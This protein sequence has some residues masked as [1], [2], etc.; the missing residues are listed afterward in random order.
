[1]KNT[2]HIYL[3]MSALASLLVVGCAGTTASEQPAHQPP[4]SETAA[5]QSQPAPELTKAAARSAQN[6]TPRADRPVA[7]APADLSQSKPAAAKKF[8]HIELARQ[9]RPEPRIVHF[10]FDKTAIEARDRE[11]LKQH[12]TYL[13]NHPEAIL[14]IQGHTDHHGPKA[15]N[16]YLSKQRAEAVARTLIEYGAPESQLVIDAMGDSQPLP[17]PHTTA[18]NRRVELNYQIL[19]MVHSH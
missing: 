16:E 5:R 2:A 3:G 6:D 11:L 15:Y 10:G 12:A 13:Q 1:M 17:Q 19:E 14:Q 18:Q 8:P 4:A 7:A 9:E